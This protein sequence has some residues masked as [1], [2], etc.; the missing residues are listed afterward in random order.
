MYAVTCRLCR[1]GPAAGDPGA[2]EVTAAL[3]RLAS[4]PPFEHVRA[5]DR[6]RGVDLVVFV[7]A[8]D[9]EAAER[10]VRELCAAVLPDSGGRR[11]W[12]LAS[13][14]VELFTPLAEIAVS[15]VVGRQQGDRRRGNERPR[16]G[17]A[18]ENP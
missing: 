12:Y 16:H 14:A 5:H 11:T 1:A 6:Q 3:R 7:T 8:A 2:D 9:L 18:S 10:Y 13:C 15:D 4:S 17:D